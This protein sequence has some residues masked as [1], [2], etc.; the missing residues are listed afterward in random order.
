MLAC[1]WEMSQ[2]R[3]EN[4]Q[5]SR[6]SASAALHMTQGRSLDDPDNL[7]RY[8]AVHRNGATEMS[9]AEYGAF[10]RDGIRHFLLTSIVVRCW[11]A[12]I[13]AQAVADKWSIPGPWEL[14]LALCTTHN[15]ILANVGEGWAEPWSFQ[16]GSPRRCPE[17]GLLFRLELDSLPEDAAI[18]TLAD[19]LGGW[20]ED[21]FGYRERRFRARRGHFDGRLDPREVVS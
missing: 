5:N 12:L 4:I 3:G 17:P 16:A 19:R 9:L 7:S 14:T 8:L 2:L 13:T 15:A 10:E 20:V 21:S 11:A 6:P 18:Q 1:R